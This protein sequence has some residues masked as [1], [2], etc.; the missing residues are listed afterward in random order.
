MR[1]KTLSNFSSKFIPFLFILCYLTTYNHSQ[2][3][4]K[5][6]LLQFVTFYKIDILIEKTRF[7]LVFSDSLS[8]KN[9]LIINLRR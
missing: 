1:S 3:I 9:Q 6:L 4:F 5:L 8:H 7:F 2:P